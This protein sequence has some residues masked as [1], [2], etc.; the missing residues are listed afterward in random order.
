MASHIFILSEKVMGL[1]HYTYIRS[2]VSL[3]ASAVDIVSNGGLETVV[4]AMKSFEDDASIQAA[5]CW[6]LASIS[7]KNGIPHV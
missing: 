7:A 3:D 2:N 4:A 6:V 1:C 5:G